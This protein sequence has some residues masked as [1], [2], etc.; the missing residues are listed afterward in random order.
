VNI[1]KSKIKKLRS[2]FFLD[3]NNKVENSVL[4]VGDGR[5]G[6]TW[7]SNIIN[8]NNEYRYMFE[9]FHPYYVKIA[10]NFSFF[11][12][13]RPNNREKD[14]LRIARTILTGQLRNVR[15]DKYND[16]PR[17]LFR[18]RLIKDIF[19]HLFLKWI[20]VQF[21]EVPII[22]ILRHPCAVAISKQHTQSWIWLKNPEDFLNQPDLIVDFLYPFNDFIRSA[23][24]LSFFEKQILI[25]CIVHYVPL[26]QFKVGQIH[27]A[28]YE[29]FCICPNEEIHRLFSFLGKSLEEESINTLIF[30]QLKQPSQMSRSGSAINTGKSLIEG[31]RK[32]VSQ[33]QLR[34][35]VQ[36]LREFKLNVIYSF[37]STPNTAEVHNLLRK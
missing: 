4:L 11:Q 33:T 1:T 35:A 20:N 16:H 15:V 18:K 34:Q 3:L 32:E 6:T 7:V 25:W 29:N 26:Q 24:N 9:P 22:L 17:F 31:W 36:I 37:D 10:K 8:Y 14:Y 28:F 23:R 2:L 12:Y 27:L 5:S 19:T 13:L 21:P 30:Q